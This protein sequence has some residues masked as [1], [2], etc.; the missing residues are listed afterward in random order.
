MVLK[1]I[2][3]SMEWPYHCH[4]F[5]VCTICR[6]PACKEIHSPS[7]TVTHT[8]DWWSEGLHGLL[9]KRKFIQGYIRN[10]NLL[11][12]GKCSMPNVPY[13]Y[14]TVQPVTAPPWKTKCCYRLQRLLT[15]FGIANGCWIESDS[16]LVLIFLNGFFYCCI[17]GPITKRMVWD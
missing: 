10:L 16:G 8:L 7:S 12:W 3:P 1:F 2:K 6:R 5:A 9:H 14:W 17:S 15:L 13:N 11:K 4:C